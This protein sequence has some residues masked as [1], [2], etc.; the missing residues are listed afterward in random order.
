MGVNHCVAMAKNK[1]PPRDARG[2]MRKLVLGENVAE[3]HR[4]R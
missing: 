1:N 2:R 3:K 4:P